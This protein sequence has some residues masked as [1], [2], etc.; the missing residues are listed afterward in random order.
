MV[1]YKKSSSGEAF[2]LVLSDRVEMRLTTALASKEVGSQFRG[3]FAEAGDREAEESLEESLSMRHSRTP[4]C[5]FTLDLGVHSNTFSQFLQSISCT[6]RKSSFFGPVHCSAKRSRSL[7]A[8]SIDWI[9][10]VP[11]CGCDVLPQLIIAT[12][13]LETQQPD[14][15]P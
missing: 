10:L 6:S 5:T 4:S 11:R 3:P 9:W 13:T 12:S 8:R 7:G 2:H 15:R 1:K 14:P